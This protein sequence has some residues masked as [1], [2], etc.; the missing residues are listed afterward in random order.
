MVIKIVNHLSSSLN[1]PN[2]QKLGISSAAGAD[3]PVATSQC[4]VIYS[5]H[6]HNFIHSI[7]AAQAQNKAIT[8]K[9]HTQK[10]Y[11]ILITASR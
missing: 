1:L 3:G 4:N 11:N 9:R 7:N 10:V 8:M 5:L 6:L 2:I